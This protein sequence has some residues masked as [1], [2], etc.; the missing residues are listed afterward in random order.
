MAYIN[1][2]GK[3]RIEPKV[4][5]ILKRY[6]VKGT[7][8]IRD[9]SILTL[10]VK[11]GKVDFDGDVNGPASGNYQV[12]PYHFQRHFGGESYHFL[13]EVHEALNA[14]NYDGGSQHGVL[15]YLKPA[16]TGGENADIFNYSRLH[17]KKRKRPQV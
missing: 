1:Q 17:P 7:L 12:N 5:E 13:K 8:S 9:F 2:D 4:K 16:L 11:S 10:K 6:G 3:K 15:L 14:E